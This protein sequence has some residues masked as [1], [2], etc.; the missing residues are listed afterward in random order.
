MHFTGKQH[1]TESG[2][3]NFGARYYGSSNALGRFMSPDPSMV[4]VRIIGSP[5]RWNRYAY[6]V[7]NPLARVDPSG[8]Q[9]VFVYYMRDD[10]T[11]N[12]TTGRIYMYGGKLRSLMGFFLEPG[13]KGVDPLHPKGRIPSGEYSATFKAKLFTKPTK[14]LFLL[15]G[16]PGFNGIFAHNGNSPE[17]TQGCPLYGTTLGNDSVGG[18]TPF[19]GDALALFGQVASD[20]GTTLGDL[21]IDVTVMDGQWDPSNPPDPTDPGSDPPEEADAPPCYAESCNVNPQAIQQITDEVN[22]GIDGS[23]A[24]SGPPRN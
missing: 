6:A 8:A 19:R 7:N 10:T 20:D 5:Q 14:S 2:L 17:D 1:D 13:K 11:T 15:N 12:S 24:P 4:A 21:D 16:V 18:S 9:D 3:D 23:R 22:E